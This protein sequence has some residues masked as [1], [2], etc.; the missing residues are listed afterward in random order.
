MDPILAGFE[1]R[2]GKRKWCNYNL[3]HKEFIFK[4]ESFLAVTGRMG[5]SV[6]AL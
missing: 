6:I 3:N 1:M 5:F 2:T 4:I